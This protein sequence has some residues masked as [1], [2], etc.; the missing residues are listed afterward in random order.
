MNGDTPKPPD[1]IDTAIASAQAE[2]RE[3]TPITITST[4]RMIMLDWPADLTDGELAEFIGWLGTNL[5]MHLRQRRAGDSRPRL[6]VAG[7]L[8]PS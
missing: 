5:L 2:E 4:G 8:P 1:R 3:T 6:Y 7:S